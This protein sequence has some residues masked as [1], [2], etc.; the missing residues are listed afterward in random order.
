[1]DKILLINIEL[2]RTACSFYEGIQSHQAEYACCNNE[3]HG[4][5]GYFK[6]AIGILR[7]RF[8]YTAMKIEQCKLTFFNFNSAVGAVLYPDKPAKFGFC[9]GIHKAGVF[10]IVLWIFTRC[11]LRMK[12]IRLLRSA[13]E[14]DCKLIGGM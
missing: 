10:W 9:T 4:L 5:V 6:L 13:S 14:S 12:L 1:M 11:R 7:L 2:G 8:Y 3:Q